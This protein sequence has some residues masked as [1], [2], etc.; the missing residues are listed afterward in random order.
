MVFTVKDV[1][2]ILLD[3]CRLTLKD[4]EK[5]FKSRIE[6]SFL[7]QENFKNLVYVKDQKIRCLENRLKNIGENLENIIDARLFEK[8][9]QLLYELDASN[10][11]LSL[12]KNSIYDLERS[13]VS[14]IHGEQLEKFSRK[15]NEL[16]L[17]DI[18]FNKYKETIMN[19]IGADFAE[20]QERIKQIIKDKAEY[21]KNQEKDS[22]FKRINLYPASGIPANMIVQ[23]DKQSEGINGSVVSGLLS[24]SI[25][26]KGFEHYSF[27]SCYKP[28]PRHP[29]PTL[30]LAEIE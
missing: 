8:G 30:E 14:R 23:A 25:V 12:F 5:Q 15:N 1:N 3:F 26:P 16:S 7:Q 13:L 21:A 24:G 20:E 29:K 6:S 10:R 19:M 27:C 17:K 11:I 4:N 9:N 22:T 18:K 28:D 2:D